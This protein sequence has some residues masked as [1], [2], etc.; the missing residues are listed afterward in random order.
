ME[1]FSFVRVQLLGKN[2]SYFWMGDTDIKYF[3][4]SHKLLMILLG[5]PLI[6]IVIIGFPV[7]VFFSLRNKKDQ[8]RSEKVVSRYGFFY[9]SY[10][11]RCNYWEVSIYLRKATIAIVT[12][13]SY[14][15]KPLLQGFLSIG[16]LVISL[17]AQFYYQPYKEPKLNKMEEVSIFTSLTVY[18]LGGMVQCN[19]GNDAVQVALSITMIIVL[20]TF[21]GYMLIECGIAYWRKMQE[22]IRSQ[23][24]YDDHSGDL[25]SI[26]YVTMRVFS[27]KSKD[28]LS[29]VKF[30]VQS[31]FTLRGSRGPSQD[32][33]SSSQD[34]LMSDDGEDSR[35]FQYT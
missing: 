5:V 35:F 18:I 30:R 29:S 28:T 33:T 23:G 20:M 17:A 21:V 10:K 24:E 2:L 27:S 22:F 25:R 16:T 11:S 6:V 26:L 12:S 9:Q 31:L 32:D 8:L 3:D 7:F 4:L 15:L 19:V 14:A 13:S 1:I 34:P